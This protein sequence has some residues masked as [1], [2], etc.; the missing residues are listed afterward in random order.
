M[1]RKQF[2]SVS[3]LHHVWRQGVCLCVLALCVQACNLKTDDILEGTTE[4]YTIKNPNYGEISGIVENEEAIA[5]Y[6]IESNP[7]GI[8]MLEFTGDGTFH[9]TYSSG[10]PLMAPTRADDLQDESGIDV[11]VDGRTVH[12]PLRAGAKTRGDTKRTYTGTYTYKNGRYEWK[13]TSY[14]YFYIAG[15]EKVYIHDEQGGE[16]W[17]YRVTKVTPVTLD[18]LTQ[19]LC[20]KWKLN[21][22]VLKLYNMNSKDEG[23]KGKLVFTYHL[24]EKELLQ[25]CVE[26]FLFSRYGNFYRYLHDGSNNG[27][28]IWNW[29]VQSEQ[30]LHYRF[31]ELD[32]YGHQS[33]VGENDLT[34]YFSNNYLY[35]TEESSGLNEYEEDDDGNMVAL[36]AVLLYELEVKGMEQK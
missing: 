24:S 31:T 22:V 20:H 13:L 3:S 1:L 29:K 28:G 25:Y 36:K 9:I 35:L 16:D 14:Q 7:F 23:G 19:R 30:A 21:R 15:E 8:D 12:V 26:T 2:C 27:N 10:T 17:S 4:S 33:L 32:Y 6:K 34:V 11:A 5:C 18:A